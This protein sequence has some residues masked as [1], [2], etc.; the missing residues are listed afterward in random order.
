MY[1]QGWWEC[2]YFYMNLIINQIICQIS[3]FAWWW[4]CRKVNIIYSDEGHIYVWTARV[5][6]KQSGYA[7]KEVVFTMYFSH[8]RNPISPTGRRHQDGDARYCLNMENHII[9]IY[10]TVNKRDV[11]GP[12]IRKGDFTGLT[13]TLCALT[14]RFYMIS[15]KVDWGALMEVWVLRVV[16]VI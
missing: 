7:R 2:H 10:F 6:E 8:I 11:T 4:R 16:F 9:H 5:A 15:N 14:S 13:L 3:D 1:S 12:E